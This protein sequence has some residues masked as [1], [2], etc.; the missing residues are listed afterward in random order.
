MLDGYFVDSCEL[1][2]TQR[3]DYGDE[4]EGVTQTLA[5]RWRDIT[6]VR[7]GSHM[8]TNDSNVLVHFAPTAPIVRGS[9]VKHDGEYFQVERITFAK[10]LGETTVQFIKCEL[11]VTSLGVS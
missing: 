6:M 8:D 2:T 10:R 7:R 11:K 1:V 9:V 5:C 4:I 3:N